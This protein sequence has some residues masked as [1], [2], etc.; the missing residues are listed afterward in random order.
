MPRVRIAVLIAAAVA[1]AVGV[2][3]PAH[4]Q[5]PAPLLFETAAARVVTCAACHGV[6]GNSKSDVMPI[7]AGMDAAYFKKQI[8]AYSTNARPSP[9][10]GPYAKQVLDIGVD[11]VAGYFAAQRMEPTPV[12]LDAAAVERGRVA[13]APCVICHGANGKGDAARGIPSMAGQPPG[14]L[15]EQMQLFKRDA[16]NPGDAALAALKALMK[17]LPDEQFADLA[18]Y[19]AS[20][21]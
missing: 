16:R 8:Q 11:T 1:A 17:T 19:Y 4:A 10:M 6:N 15:R 21:R 7:I 2:A 3:A 9:E 13:S 14:Y 5:T 12:K 20:L 18:A